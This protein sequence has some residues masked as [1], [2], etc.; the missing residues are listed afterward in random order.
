MVKLGSNNSRMR[1]FYDLFALQAGRAFQGERLVR[2]LRATFVRRNTPL[3]PDRPLAL[4]SA[5]AEMAAQRW[6]AFVS[7]SALRAAPKELGEV[8]TALEKFI[9]PVA[10]A[11]RDGLRFDS[12]WAPGGPWSVRK[13][14]L[15][16]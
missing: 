9:W 8:I 6:R 14:S 3:P 15:N 5:F 7:K 13:R 10:D 11:A 1:D 16:A 4:T 2:A 12:I